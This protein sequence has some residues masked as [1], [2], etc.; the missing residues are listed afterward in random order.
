MRCPTLKELPLP[1]RG[2]TGW[3]WTV[4][5]EPLPDVMPD[6]G[7]WPRISIVTPTY[8]QSMFIEETIRSIL[9]QRYPNIE[10]VIM[11]GGSGDGTLDIIQRYSPWLTYWQS[12][13]DGGQSEAINNGFRRTTGVILNWVCSDDF[14]LPNAL[15]KVA[16]GMQHAKWIIGS[17]HSLFEDG[18]RIEITHE[19]Y[20]RWDVL[21]NGYV[22]NQVSVFWSSDLFKLVGGVQVGLFYAMDARL[23]ME[24]E[25]R[26]MP[27]VIPTPLGAFRV[28]RAQKT[29]D[30]VATM[31]EI[32]KTRA[33]LIEDRRLL[34]IASR[35]AWHLRRS[36][37]SVGIGPG[38]GY[39]CR[40][41]DI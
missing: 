5:S 25:L 11:D 8:K 36:A 3:P 19:A 26:A 29:A 24:F 1:P 9:L 33:E 37:G 41:I 12:G 10:Y 6:G 23:W 27:T 21:F 2:K 30:R 18:R 17:A 39:R 35:F 15:R 22:L 40:N 28:H 7:P 38:I 20:S 14:L 32:W 13:H 4:D 34:H 16:G 31:N